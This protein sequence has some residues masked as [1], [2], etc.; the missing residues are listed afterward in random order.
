MGKMSL[1]IDGIL[2]AQKTT[3]AT[4]ILSLTTSG[5]TGLGIGNTLTYDFPMVGEIEE[6]VLYSR[7]L[8]AVEVATLAVGTCQPRRATA[9]A[10]LV[11]QF[12]VGAT[13]TDGG[14]GYVN[15]P[16][17]L[18][19][20]GGG[21][22]AAATAVVSNGIV[23]NI[24][25]TDAG[26]GYTSTPSIY[27]YCPLGLPTIGLVKAVKPSFTDLFIGTNYQLQV[28]ADMNNWTNQGSPFAAT[29]TI[30]VYP[31]YLDVE[32]WGQLFFRLQAVP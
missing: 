7:A 22:G 6:V 23:V 12:V 32:N 27:I 3:S 8:S 1:Y 17:V 21:T 29:N 28:S 13:V 16:Q 15:T 31:L 11:N 14:C 25:I 24:T 18:I 2:A 19:Q 9:T 26:I 4:P 5:D 20:G 10:Q 30:M